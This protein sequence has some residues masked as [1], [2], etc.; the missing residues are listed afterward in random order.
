MSCRVISFQYRLA[1]LLYKSEEASRRLENPPRNT[2]NMKEFEEPKTLQRKIEENG[3][4]NMTFLDDV[5]QIF[6]AHDNDFGLASSGP[7]S[8][9]QYA[10]D[11]ESLA[12]VRLETM[13]PVGPSVGIHT[14][15]S[16]DC[17]A[18]SGGL[19][20][21]DL[22]HFIRTLCAQK[23]MKSKKRKM[24]H[25]MLSRTALTTVALFVEELATEM[26]LSWKQKIANHTVA[27]ESPAAPV[28][29]SPAPSPSGTR[30]TDDS[31]TPFSRGISNCIRLE[32][33]SR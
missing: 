12:G 33:N 11:V 27:H 13:E 32:Y 14:G 4:V 23:A 24:V 5:S 10:P 9:P 8:Q 17:G 25:A 19:P 28:A 29:T 15:L 3:E 7:P 20:P 1:S 18:E 2:R 22:Q 6:G 31:D 16:G 21:N 26:V 30:T